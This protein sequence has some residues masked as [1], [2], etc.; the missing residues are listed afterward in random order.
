M[1]YN[2]DG[3]N[4]TFDNYTPTDFRIY[5]T[6]EMREI[7]KYTFSTADF[8][9]SFI[10]NNNIK[11][12][13]QKYFNSWADRIMVIQD[14]GDISTWDVSEVTDMYRL[15]YNKLVPVNFID[16]WDV[17]NVVN[18]KEMFMYAQFED[19]VNLNN[20]NVQ[21]GEN[22]EKMFFRYRTSNLIPKI[23]DWVFND[24]VTNMKQM[25]VASSNINYGNIGLMIIP[26]VHNNVKYFVHP[27]NKSYLPLNVY[28]NYSE[29]YKYNNSSSILNQ[30]HRKKILNVESFITSEKCNNPK[31]VFKITTTS[32]GA[33]EFTVETNYNFFMNDIQIEMEYIGNNFYIPSNNLNN[34][35]YNVY[36]VTNNYYSRK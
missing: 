28:F 35:T 36:V 32:E 7:A 29:N 9:K 18:F 8:E 10:T 11:S 26:T 20:W 31:P 1:N 19:N 12:L 15:F 4:E 23:K 21:K 6:K 17:S 27:D 24:K 16:M 22:F 14:Y 30:N 5:N 33:N 3:V 13:I 25:F 2:N 34:G